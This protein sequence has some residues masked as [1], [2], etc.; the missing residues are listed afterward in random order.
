MLRAS[1]QEA[2]WNSPQVRVPPDGA[3]AA[4]TPS[5]ADMLTRP[6]LMPPPPPPGRDDQSPRMDP[7]ASE[8][9][10]M[11]GS[12]S[13]PDA[14]AASSSSGHGTD[15]QSQSWGWQEQ[16]AQASTWGQGK[17]NF[18]VGVQRDW[19]RVGKDRAAGPRTGKRGGGPALSNPEHMGG[20]PP[21]P[22][23]HGRDAACVYVCACARVCVCACVRLGR[24]GLNSQWISAVRAARRRG[25]NMEDRPFRYQYQYQ[26]QCSVYYPRTSASNSTSASTSASASASASVLSLAT[27]TFC[28]GL[29]VFLMKI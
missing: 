12:S 15:W 18:A 26:C 4:S 1:L 22:Q 17:Q 6:P 20:T 2:P 16:G 19:I 24:S 7:W 8:T 29:I 21:V 5:L 25:E 23:K 9:W 10:Q 3:S 14:Q 13:A 27:F 28:T 11:P